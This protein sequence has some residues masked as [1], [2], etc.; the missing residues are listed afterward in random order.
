MEMNTTVINNKTYIEID[1]ITIKN[2]E[3]VYLMNKENNED[4]FIRKLAVRDGKVYYD[5]L[6]DKNEFDTAMMYF[7]KK[8][9]NMLDEEMEDE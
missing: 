6:E 5:G 1:K 9:E 3:Y 8:H 4:F 7:V 2:Q